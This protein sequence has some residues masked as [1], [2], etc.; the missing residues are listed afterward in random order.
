MRN[1]KLSASDCWG[2]L[3]A[4]EKGDG[5]TTTDIAK[6]F[7]WMRRAAVLNRLTWLAECG[8]IRRESAEGTRKAVRWHPVEAHNG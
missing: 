3:V 4:V 2:V 7:P 6:G 1:I 5:R 8:K